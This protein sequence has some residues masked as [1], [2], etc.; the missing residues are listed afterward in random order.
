[1]VAYL[2]Y[3]ENKNAAL[4]LLGFTICSFL[5][6]QKGLKELKFKPL[7]ESD[8]NTS[9]PFKGVFMLKMSTFLNASPDELL[10]YLIDPSIRTL[11]DFNVKN[12]KNND[13]NE[14]VINYYSTTS[15]AGLMEKISFKYMAEDDKFYI[16]EYASSPILGKYNRVWILEQVQNRPNT[17]R[18]NYLAEVKPGYASIREG[19]LLIVRSFQALKNM[20]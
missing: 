7:T 5:M 18:I 11:W 1:M 3:T 8:F 13:K 20:I 14:L 4:C 6:K 15:T 10:R 19:G 2:F 12:A 9:P 16:I 17:M